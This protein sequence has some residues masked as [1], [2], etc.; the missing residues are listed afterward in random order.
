[1]VGLGLVQSYSDVNESHTVSLLVGLE[2]GWNV[3]PTHSRMI[4]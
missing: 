3:Q 2:H 4:K 1:M